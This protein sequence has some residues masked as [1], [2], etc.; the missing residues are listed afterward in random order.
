MA[1][2]WSVDA[3]WVAFTRELD[4]GSEVRLAQRDG[5]AETVVG[6]GD[7]ASWRRNA[8]ELLVAV[9]T[10]PASRAYTFDLATRKTVEVVRVEKLSI[11]V[12]EWHPALDRFA[13]VASEGAGR[14]ASGGIWIRAADGSGAS[15]LDVGLTVLAPQWSRD[16]SMLTALGGGSE[17]LVPIVDLLSGRRVSVVCRRGGTPPADCL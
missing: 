14:E 2:A 3:A 12:V 5:G 6:P 7:K 10:A 9:S 13:Y 16:G 1:L 11:P 17:A 8:P 4:E 15:R